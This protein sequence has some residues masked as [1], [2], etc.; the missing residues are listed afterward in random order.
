MSL[1]VRLGDVALSR[2]RRASSR[3]ASFGRKSC[4]I[5]S[6]P[7]IPF[8]VTLVAGSSPAFVT[9]STRDVRSSANV[10]GE[11]YQ[12]RIHLKGFG[13]LINRVVV[14]SGMVIRFA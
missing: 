1:S 12:V 8:G 10:I 4:T 5:A 6:N 13:N 11:P 2:Y 3:S 7:G 9:S 14:L